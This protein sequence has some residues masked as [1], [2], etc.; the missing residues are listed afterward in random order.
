LKSSPID[1][2]ALM[3]G[4]SNSAGHETFSVDQET[5]TELHPVPFHKDETYVWNLWDLRRKAIELAN[6]RRKKTASAQTLTSY[7][8]LDI[9]SQRYDL[10]QKNSQT[11]E[12]KKINT[13]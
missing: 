13:E 1:V 9:A 8:R 6:L 12:T 2:D 4:A 5:Q 10:H 7:H 3:E 11:N